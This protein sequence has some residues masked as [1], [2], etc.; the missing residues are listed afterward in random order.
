[1]ENKIKEANWI[2]TNYVTPHEYVVCEKY[3]ELFNLLKEKVKK[4]GYDKEFRYLKYR[5]MVRYCD[6]K[7]YTYWIT[8]DC[9]NRKLKTN[10]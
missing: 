3:P 10:S 2:K 8:G 1:M 7:G 6:Y 9:L 4:E 5:K